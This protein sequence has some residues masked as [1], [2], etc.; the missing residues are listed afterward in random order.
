MEE[1]KMTFE[2]NETNEQE[3]DE[4]E[5]LPAETPKEEE[6]KAGLFRKVWNGITF[7][8]RWC[9]RKLKESPA[10]GAVGMV[11][12]TGLTLGVKAGLNHFHKGSGQDYIPAETPEI[13]VPEEYEELDSTT[14][15]TED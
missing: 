6:K 15:E 2:E 11:I 14:Y 1:N 10:A 9:G 5:N 8:P 7:V 13:E 3:H 4:N 12:G